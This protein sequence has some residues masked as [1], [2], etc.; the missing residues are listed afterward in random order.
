VRKAIEVLFQYIGSALRRA[1]SQ[2]RRK[3][4]GGND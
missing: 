2:S 4:P 3:G 1:V